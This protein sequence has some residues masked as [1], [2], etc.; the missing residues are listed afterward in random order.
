MADGFTSLFPYAVR[1]IQEKMMAS[2]WDALT[3]GGHVVIEAGTGSGKTISALAPTLEYAFAN[4]K[5]VLYLTRTNSQ[6]RQVIEEFRRIRDL[7]GVGEVHENEEPLL[8]ITDQLGRILGEI[9]EVETPEREELTCT[10]DKTFDTLWDGGMA[11]GICVGLQGR[12]NMCPITSED[13]EFIGGTPEELSKMCSERKKNT[14]NR[15][16]GRP[17]D[18]KECRYFSAFL[19]DDGMEV[20]RWAK[21]VIPTAEELIDH[22]LSMG[23]CPY[24]VT[25]AIIRDAVLITAPY[26]Y[27]ISPFIRRR[28]LEWMECSIDEVI[29]IIDEAHNLSGFARE[30]SSLSIG[31]RTIRA[32][33]SEVE[34]H[35]DHEIG[36]GMFISGFLGRFQ[37]AMDRL[38]EE[39]LIDDDG[40]V[41]PSSLAEELM[42]LT[43]TNS[44]RVD[45]LCTRLTHHGT[46]IQDRKKA[47]G[48]LPRSY[49]HTV[50]A[51][52][53]TWRDLEFERYT[54]LIVKGR[55]EDSGYLE[56]FSMDPSTLTGV[57]RE[58]HASIHLSGTLSP[59]EEYRDSIGLPENASLISMSPPFPPG[60]R[61]LVHSK[62]LTTNY[63]QL[64][65]DPE[66]IE[67]FRREIVDILRV[68]R[69]RNL[70]IFFPSFDLL[71]RILGSP[72]LED[73]T[74][75]PPSIDCGREMFIERRGSS[76]S[77]V[78]DLVERFKVSHGGV[79]ASVIGGRLSEG[80]DYPGSELEIV[81][82]VGIPYPK[83]NA[84]QRALLAYYDIRFGKG[85]EY[86]VIAPAARRMLQA[87][88]RMIR[89]GEERGF[90]II[91]DKRALHFREELTGI[92][93][94]RDIP[95]VLSRFFQGNH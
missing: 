86:T 63:E 42:F 82:I 44:N 12:S 31:S 71:R 66:M 15:M 55:K 41:P 35:G 90:G 73:G 22:S 87:L 14:M 81:I 56:A 61:M 45:D 1:P 83:P 48:K 24:E 80:V 79:L 20:R 3:S 16:A 7:Q 46:A 84:R 64:M 76:Q 60:N 9:N 68:E 13:P 54:P 34:R 23:I 43:G 62:E 28:L 78:M 11:E 33:L 39:Y 18:G 51:F 92:S 6:Q 53:L 74:S 47:E 91:L 36:G 93:E 19:L 25:K 8:D 89:S 49:I 26:I 40:L 29:V 10:R 30:L 67:M 32:A 4:R 38:T 95:M 70:A 57:L 52:Y 50:G 85:W 17:N 94:E 58:V 75:L 69:G 37:T 88:G 27:F 5:R 65:R 2:V 59:L 77:E 21:R 72:E